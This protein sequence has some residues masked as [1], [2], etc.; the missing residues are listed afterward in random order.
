M[1]IVFDCSAEYKGQSLNHHLLSGPDLT[2]NLVGV[3]CRFR[4]QP[5][6]FTCDIEGM[7][8]QVRVILEHRDFLRFL[9]WKNGAIDL[10]PV[11]YRMTV[12]LFGAMSSPGCANF[13]L[14]KA[15]DDFEDEFGAEVASFIR[16]NF[17]VDDGLKS[18]ADP[19]VAIDLIRKS[20]ELCKK[21]GFN[22]HKFI[23]NRKEVIQRIPKEEQA[24]GIQNLDLSQNRLPIERAL[25]VQWCVE[26]DTFQFRIEVK[27]RP[28]TRRGIL[29][30][31]SS[32]FDPLG[33]VAPF[34]LIGKRILQQLCR[35]GVDWDDRVPEDV[36]CEWEKWREQLHLLT[37]VEIQRC[38]V[39][40]GFK[41][42]Q[43]VE[44]HNFSDASQFVMGNFSYLRLVDKE[45]NVY[46]TL[47][48]GEI[49]SRTP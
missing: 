43:T 23:S 27:D 14:K 48:M 47:V 28:L 46:C 15:A 4:Q 29:S 8:H 18:V 9:W 24:K 26:S 42:L 25:G 20:K 13:A 16:D 12:H 10:E 35:G 37:K 45:N 38:Y 17:Y 34:I 40:E 22:L 1:R 19:D 41:E 32:V 21:G 6:A 49:T 33:L 36:R 11:E 7:F 5:V 31:V 39:P 2:N 44:L 30:T 3:L